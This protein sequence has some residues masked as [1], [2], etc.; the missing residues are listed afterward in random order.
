MLIA[1]RSPRCLGAQA[2]VGVLNRK[3]LF[4]LTVVALL[5]AKFLH[6]FS[7]FVSVSLPLF[8]LYFPTFMT[9]DIFV[10]VASRI[11]FPRSLIVSVLL[12]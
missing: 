2:A 6:L 4:A 3:F 1:V 10:I 12:W 9:P 5:A 11:L 7:H 8:V